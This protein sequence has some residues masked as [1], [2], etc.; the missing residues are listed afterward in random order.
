MKRLRMKC[1][2][3]V[4]AAVLFNSVSTDVA[5]SK[6]LMLLIAGGMGREVGRSSMRKLYEED[7]KPD[8]SGS[9][10][11]IK[12]LA[13]RPFFL[14]HLIADDEEFKNEAL[15]HVGSYTNIVLVGHSLGGH[16][17]Y[18]IHSFFCLRGLK[19]PFQYS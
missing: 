6:P 3:I 18:K 10:I 14:A 5:E 8:C 17:A 13:N 16:T 7:L 1:L 11:D 19:M 15:G 2:I 4:A 9:H 12:L